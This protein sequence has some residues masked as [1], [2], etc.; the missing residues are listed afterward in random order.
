[1][2]L[3][4]NVEVSL[5][6]HLSVSVTINLFRGCQISTP[7][8]VNSVRVNPAVLRQELLRNKIRLT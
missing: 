2:L 8:F 3:R 4:Y 1:M 7:P 6:H 5:A